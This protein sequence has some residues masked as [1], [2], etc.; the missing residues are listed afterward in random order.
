M[1]NVWV[2][3][4]FLENNPLCSFKPK[5]TLY[6]CKVHMLLLLPSLEN[7]QTVFLLLHIGHFWKLH[8]DSALLKHDFFTWITQFNS[9]NLS[10]L[11][12]NLRDES[13]N[14]SINLLGHLTSVAWFMISQPDNYRL[15]DDEKLLRVL[16]EFSTSRTPYK[17]ISFQA[18][19][20]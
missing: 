6:K 13:W 12:K 10:R 14:S 8:Q 1:P 3:K 5:V 2:W 11:L 15:Q 7:I 19:P 17:S 16:N 18:V 20:K 4:E 9:R